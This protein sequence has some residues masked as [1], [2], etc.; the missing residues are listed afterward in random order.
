M[1]LTCVPG[2]LGSQ[3]KALVPGTGI[4]DGCGCWEQPEFPLSIVQV[5]NHRVISSA[6]GI[7]LIFRLSYLLSSVSQRAY[8]M[9]ASLLR[10]SNKINSIHSEYETM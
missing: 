2:A 1:C 10:I 9:A 8:K 5:L 6:P 3:K 4:R 7:M